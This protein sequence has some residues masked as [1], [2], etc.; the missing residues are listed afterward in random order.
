MHRYRTI[1]A[2][3]SGE[4]RHPASR[5]GCGLCHR[6]PRPGGGAVHRSARP[7]RVDQWWP[8]PTAR[9]QVAE[10]CVRNG[11]SQPTGKRCGAAPAHPEMPNL[12]T[13]RGSKSISA[14]EV[15]GAGR[16]IA[17]AG[18]RRAGISRGNKAQIRF[19]DLRRG[20]LATKHHEAW[21][22]HC[23]IRSHEGAREASSSSQTGCRL[24]RLLARRRARLPRAVAHPSGKIL[25]ALTAGAAA[26]SSS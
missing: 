17:D 26:V 22:D 6:V 25:T 18:V 9:L 3:R 20:A 10:T 5:P 1:P 21:P 23:S 7:L 15:L 11:W 12:P 2:A 13:G 19:L 8:I 24:S 14:N 16:R 4:K